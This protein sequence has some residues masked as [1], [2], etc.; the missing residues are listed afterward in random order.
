MGDTLRSISTRTT[1]TRERARADEVPNV[2][3]GYVFTPGD[4]VRLRRFLTLGSEGSYHAGAQDMT[5][6]NAA[7]VMRMADTAPGVL[8]STILDVSERG[9]AP[10]ANP[11]LFA[12]AVAAST[13][14][15][16]ART[17]ALDA[18]PRVARTGTHLFLFAEYVQQFR[19]WGRGLRRGIG[20]W[21]STKDP[22]DLAY[23]VVKYR[24]REGWSQRDLLRKAHPGAPTAEHRAVYEWITRGTTGE[25]TP[26]IVEGFV[27]VNEP[28]ANI[29]ALVREYR[30][31]WETLPSDALKDANVWD[32]LLDV[33]MGQTALMRNLSR[34]TRLGLLPAMGGR[35]AEVTARL[36]DVERL[37]KGRVH[38]INVLVAM[39]TY[40]QGHGARSETTWTPTRQVVDSLDAAFYAAFGAVQPAGKRTMLAIDVSGS[41]HMSPI[42]NM[43]LT[44][45]E[46]S[47]ALAMVQMATEPQTLTV[48]FTDGGRRASHG[49]RMTYAGM[50]AI[51]DTL[52]PLAI[53][54]RQRLDDAINAV[55]G[56]DF[57]RTD[58]S[59]P[60]RFAT[61]QGIEVDTFVIYTDSETNTGPVH[62]YQALRRYREQSGIDA[63]LVVVAMTANEFTIADPEDAGMLD[64]AGFDSNV[65]SLI[66]DFSRG[67]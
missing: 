23:Q 59:A 19:G 6:E 16:E 10:K 3:G 40:A 53:S 21:Y 60:M 45:R 38:P 66:T 27:K 33:G 12:L 5:R 62:P 37:T 67:L 11:A 55:S 26:R 41:M 22:A 44:P 14:P 29:P 28:G 8:L 61:A 1:P 31:P 17:A 20:S 52:T 47:A 39:R 48:G 25:H 51:G 64:V 9:A 57:G 34:L 42:S 2:S 18:L 49:G 43:P 54:P 35:T 4:E 13:G 36:Q 50:D 56:L 30:L 32:A 63:R 46:A 7:V 15:A 65:P 24:Q 58:C